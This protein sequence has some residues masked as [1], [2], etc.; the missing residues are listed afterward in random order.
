V[1]FRIPKPTDLDVSETSASDSNF[2]R[3]EFVDSTGS[4]RR[5]PTAGGI[6]PKEPQIEFLCPNGHRLHGPA[7]LQG[8]PGE[9]PECG[10]RFRIPTYEDISAEE[11]TEQEISLGRM[12]GREGSDSSKTTRHSAPNED[13]AMPTTISGRGTSGQAM[14]ASVARLWNLRPAGA[15]I[16]LRLRDGETIVPDQFL[17]KQSK[18]NHQGVFAVKESNGSLSLVTVA[19]DAIARATLRGLSEL[20]KELAE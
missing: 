4:S 10:S 1:K 12:D 8:R 6:G 15:T 17:E 18:Q 3:P 2:S 11:A 7:N 19:W 13:V 9:C 20:P 14:A 16:E 5:L